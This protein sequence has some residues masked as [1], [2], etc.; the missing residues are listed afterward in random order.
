MHIHS[1]THSFSSLLGFIPSILSP[2]CPAS[3]QLPLLW[4]F[5][6][7]MLLKHIPSSHSPSHLLFLIP[8]TPCFTPFFTE[9]SL[10]LA[11]LLQSSPLYYVRWESCCLISKALFN[12]LLPSI[13]DLMFLL[14]FPTYS[15]V[16]CFSEQGLTADAS[17]WERF[18]KEHKLLLPDVLFPTWESAF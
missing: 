17:G 8:G 13:P 10:I 6:F 1:Q 5:P 3:D 16:S 14:L 11:L 12:L 2:L 15:Q 9:P 7:E 18:R 4:I